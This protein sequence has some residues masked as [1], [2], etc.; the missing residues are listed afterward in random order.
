MAGQRTSELSAIT[1]LLS[2]DPLFVARAPIGN[3]IVYSDLLDQLE[4]E[5]NSLGNNLFVDTINN[6]V[7]IGKSNPA[8]PLH[9]Y[10]NTANTGTNAGLT[11]EQDGTGDAVLQYLITGVTRYFVG[12]DNSDGDRF[13]IT[14]EASGFGL[15]PAISIEPINDNVGIG[16]RSGANIVAPLHVYE[17]SSF[18]GNNTGLLIEQDGTGD[19]AAHFY[20]TGGQYWSMGI[21]NSDTDKFKIAPSFQVDTNTALTID[22]SSNIGV[23]TS[24]PASPLHVYE[25][26]TST[27]AST[28]LTIEQDGTGDAAAHFYLT[29]GQYWSMGIDNNLGD[30][31]CITPSTDL[32]ASPALIIDTSRNSTILGTLR[33]DKNLADA[34]LTAPGSNSSYQITIDGGTG[35]NDAAGIGFGI[36]PSLI[37][38][39]IFAV[40][41]GPSNVADLRFMTRDGGGIFERMTIDHIGNV[42][43]GTNAPTAGSRL[44]VQGG[45]IRLTDASDG[46]I[47]RTPD[48]TK[49]YRISVDNTGSVITT[50]V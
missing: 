32:G 30:R 5:I 37:S 3:K 20:L 1:T 8:S 9:V 28:G 14:S 47:C 13:K 36:N 34:I 38:A 50:L 40:D 29:G 43:I 7:G 42:G 11:I 2:T 19:A 16:V 17:N 41:Q 31:F 49:S 33:V 48:N 4:L 44:E 45:D 6:R 24:S 10:E 21:D 15:D 12:I 18:A 27:V 22:S 39:S 26:T 25:N 46:L 23:K 35:V